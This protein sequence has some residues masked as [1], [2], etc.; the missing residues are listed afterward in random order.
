MTAATSITD[1]SLIDGIGPKITKLL[2]KAGITSLQHIASLTPAKLAKLDA[3]LELK[4]RTAR[5]EWIAQAQEL[6][7]GKTPR[8]KVDQAKA[9]KKN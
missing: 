7:A 5:E 9:A 1:V 4:G 6:I 3:E 8:A 2:A